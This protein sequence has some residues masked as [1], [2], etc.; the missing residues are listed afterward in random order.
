MSN[1]WFN[2]EETFKI[3]ASTV[4][5]FLSGESIQ[6]KLEKYYI[7]SYR[8]NSE[9]SP[10]ITESISNSIST[11][12]LWAPFRHWASRRAN[13]MHTFLRNA[14][15][16][17]SC[18]MFH[19]TFQGPVFDS[20]AARTGG[21]RSRC[22]TS[23]IDWQLTFFSDCNFCFQDGWDLPK[24][25]PGFQLFI[26]FLGVFFEPS[27]IHRGAKPLMSPHTKGRC[28]NVCILTSVSA[29]WMGG[30]PPGY[31]IDKAT[32]HWENDAQTMGSGC[33]PRNVRTKSPW[34]LYVSIG[35]QSHFGFY[36][37]QV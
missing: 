28:F 26:F 25:F 34:F 5:V 10:I 9:T 16:Q 1:P 13:R 27:K 30:T 35:Y 31:P 37:P 24:I 11:W 29:I 22:W 7:E 32:C 33:F 14:L 12:N 3:I 20:E 23:F 2:S 8:I 15:K 18:G 21:G 6:K 4:C 36:T 19:R 17:S